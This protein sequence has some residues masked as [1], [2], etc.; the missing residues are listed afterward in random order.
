MWSEQGFGVQG[1]GPH[2]DKAVGRHRC[3]AARVPIPRG[4]GGEVLAVGMRVQ[5]QWGRG[6]RGGEKSKSS[7]KVT[8]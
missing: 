2:S 1:H 4:G 7:W 6:R 3:R 5:G 8:A